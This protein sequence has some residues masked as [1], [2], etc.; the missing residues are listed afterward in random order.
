MRLHRC[1]HRWYSWGSKHIPTWV[2]SYVQKYYNKG[3]M[4][5]TATEIEWPGSQVQ[6]ELVPLDSLEKK[7]ITIEDFYWSLQPKRSYINCFAQEWQESSNISRSR[8]RRSDLLVPWK[9]SSWMEKR[10]TSS[11]WIDILPESPALLNT[12]HWH[13]IPS[14]LS[15]QQIQLPVHHFKP[16]PRIW[17]FQQTRISPKHSTKVRIF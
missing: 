6:C 15:Q 10:T 14:Q 1:E 5:V 2:E 8:S 13:A 17:R 7:K 12:C 16:P 11:C 3:R 9:G 4:T